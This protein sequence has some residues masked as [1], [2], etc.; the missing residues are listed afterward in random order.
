MSFRSSLRPCLAVA[1][2]LLTAAA[3]ADD[4]SIRAH[5]TTD[6]IEI[7]GYFNEAS[8]DATEGTEDFTQ[9]EPDEGD[10]LSERTRVRVMYDDEKLYVG[11]ECWDS[12]P[13]RIVANEM[14][15]DGALWR[16]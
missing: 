3:L 7:D 16:L 11:F 12:E 14:R 2:S 9:Q 4:R 15:R 10:P 5:R 1:L 13:D 6:A 8:W